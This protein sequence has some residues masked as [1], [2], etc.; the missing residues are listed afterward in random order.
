MGG[1]VK[2]PPLN[3]PVVPVTGVV[4]NGTL[5]EPM[6]S[7]T[8]VELGANP[9]PETVAEAPGAA[10]VSAESFEANSEI[11]GST[12][13]GVETARELSSTTRV[14]L[15]W[16]NPVGTVHDWV[17]VPLPSVDAKQ[18]RF[19]AVPWLS[20]TRMLMSLLGQPVPLTSKVWPE[21]PVVGVTVRVAAKT[22]NSTV[23]MWPE[24]SLTVIG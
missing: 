17:S 5:V 15:P 23:P 7:L 12:V 18:A 2:A 16:I 1:T 14:Y 10:E 11:P 6:V 8:I 20:S 22:F 24:L 9:L 13:I 19:C 4:V 21:I 3:E